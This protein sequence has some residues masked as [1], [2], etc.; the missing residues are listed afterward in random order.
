M[1]QLNIRG[2]KTE[3]ILRTMGQEKPVHSYILPDLEVCGLETRDYIDLPKV[4][5][6]R[7]IPVKKENILRQ[8]DVQRW[9]YLKEVQIPRL[10]AEIGL[11]I[12]TNA[13]RAMEPW[14]VIN[15]EGD[16]PYA[17]KTT[18]GWVVLTGSKRGWQQVS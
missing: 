7:D 9:P 6:H 15:S 10:E 4:F 3:I 1:R 2:R 13:P 14:R 17:V 16:G 12:G 11:L 5:I 18:L 8:E